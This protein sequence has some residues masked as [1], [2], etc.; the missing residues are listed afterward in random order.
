MERTCT[1]L[2][3]KNRKRTKRR[4]SFRAKTDAP[5]PGTLGEALVAHQPSPAPAARARASLLGIQAAS[6]AP[7]DAP[8]Q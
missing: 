3:A 2:L 8:E 7:S 1:S 6:A 5:V 4:G